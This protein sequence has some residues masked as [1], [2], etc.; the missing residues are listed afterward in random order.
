[1]RPL[2]ERP[3][4]HTSSGAF[5]ASLWR[6]RTSNQNGRCSKLLLPKLQLGAVVSRSEVPQGA[7]TLEHPGGQ[8]SRPTEDGGLPGCV[9]P[10]DS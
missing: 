10:A 2:S 3:S 6:L 4:I 7:A 8:G 9:I 5:L 1:M